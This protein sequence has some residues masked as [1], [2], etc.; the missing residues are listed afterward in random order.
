MRT[1]STVQ[2]CWYLIK[3]K[4]TVWFLD[5]TFCCRR[6]LHVIVGGRT[7]GAKQK[8]LML[9]VHGFPE[10]WYSWRHQLKV[11]R[12]SCVMDCVRV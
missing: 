12:L 11:D 3:A 1:A 5:V 4:S 8:P 2:S 9:F 10:L 6:R 7:Q